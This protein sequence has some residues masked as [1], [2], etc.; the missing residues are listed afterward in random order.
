MHRKVLQD[1]EYGHDIEEGY[2]LILKNVMY[3]QNI[4]MTTIVICV[5]F[6]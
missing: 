3:Y 6:P 5:L 4:L 1:P 2:G